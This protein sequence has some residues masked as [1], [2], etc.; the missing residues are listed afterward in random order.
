MGP[1]PG[2][3]KTAVASARRSGG[4]GTRSWQSQTA[5]VYL[6][7]VTLEALPRMRSSSLKQS[8]TKAF[9][10]KFQ[11]AFL[12]TK[13]TTA[14]S[15]TRGSGGSEGFTSSLLT[16]PEEK[17]APL[18]FYFAGTGWQAVTGLAPQP[19]CNL[20]VP[21]GPVGARHAELER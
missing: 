7:P 18:R 15:S 20:L 16:G 3:K 17:C 19:E 11:T 4:K 14:T 10:T 1:D 13:R 21:R 8:L 6:S 2:K 9:W 5:M 12:E